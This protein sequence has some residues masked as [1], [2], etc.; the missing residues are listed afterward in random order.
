VT[1]HISS[2][3][4]LFTTMVPHNG[5]FV[6]KQLPSNEL[7]VV[8][9]CLHRSAFEVNIHTVTSVSVHESQRESRGSSVSIVTRLWDG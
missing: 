9:Y 1:S 5:V 8:T 7:V 2:L 4:C 6:H 3:V